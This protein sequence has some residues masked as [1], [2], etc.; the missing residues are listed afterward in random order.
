MRVLIVSQYFWPENFRINDLVEGLLDRDHEITVLTGLPNYPSG[1]FVPG[2]GWSGPYRE[3][4]GKADVL[5]VP[6]VPRGG[7]GGLKLTINYLT[8]AFFASLVGPWRLP[9]PYDVIFVYEPS[10]ITVGIPA[11]IISWIKKAPIVFW[12]QDLWPESLSATGAV[13][14]QSI[15]NIVAYLVRWIY[16]GCA[17]VLVQS[18]AF[19]DPVAQMGVPQDRIAYFPNSAEALY[20]PLPAQMPWDGPALPDGFRIMFAGN[21]GAAQ[22]FET[23]L[24]AA[25]ILRPHLQIKWIIVGDGRL[26]GWLE[27]EVARRGLQDCIHLVGRFPAESMSRWFAQADVMLTTLCRDPIF[28]LTI[29]AKVQS[30]MACAKP[31]VAALDGEGARIVEAAGAGIAVPAEDSQALA[32]AVLRLQ[33]LPASELKVMGSRGRSYFESHFERNYLLDRLEYWLD[34]VMV[35]RR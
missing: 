25:E 35:K 4:F 1:S 6:V 12:V 24:S 20:T 30:Y 2:Y 18:E 8:F 28:A 34:D 3:S 15:L 10:P 26:R 5:R 13:K 21:I 11:R 31:I 23:L 16:R 19:F 27:S 22:S 7:G 33:C 17:R 29:P 9:G 32:D 14:S